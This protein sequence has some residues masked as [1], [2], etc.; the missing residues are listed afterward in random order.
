MGLRD[1]RR[2]QDHGEGEKERPERV[3]ELPP[4]IVGERQVGFRAWAAGISGR[5]SARK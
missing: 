5:E 4:R 3:H 1:A 2:K